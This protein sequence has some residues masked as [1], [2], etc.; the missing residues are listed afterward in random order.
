MHN[1]HVNQLEEIDAEIHH[2]NQLYDTNSVITDRY[3]S[4]CEFKVQSQI[5]SNKNVS[6]LHWNVRS[7]LPKLDEITSELEALSGDF[8]LLC[9]C[10]TWL[11]NITKDLA[12]LDNYE[13]FHSCRDSRFPGRCVSIFAKPH[14]NPKLLSKFQISLPFFESVGIE[15]TKFNKKYLICEIYRPPRCIPSE[16][17]EKL[18][19]LFNNNLQSTQYEEIFLCGDYNLNL[20][21]TES[22]NSVSQFV[23]QMSSYS[24]LPVISRPTRIT[25]QTSSLIDNIFIK[26]PT[27]FDSGLIISTISDHL[28]IFIMKPL[29]LTRLDH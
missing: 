12:A 14:L 22:N 18:D 11:T 15:C 23:N 1:N 19:S 16:F 10:E 7:I 24:L 29:M 27:N 17:L 20:L 4:A 26:H 8:D 28:P 25:E 21:D 2:F 13:P 9:F 3:L 6:V 5:S